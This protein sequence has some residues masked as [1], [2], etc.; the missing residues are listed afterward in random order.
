MPRAHLGANLTCKQTAR[1]LDISLASQYLTG[2]KTSPLI[3][4]GIHG[5]CRLLIGRTHS[6][7]GLYIQYVDASFITCQHPFARNLQADLRKDHSRL[8]AEL[9]AR[10][11]RHAAQLAE[12]A[13]ALQAEIDALKKQ[14]ESLVSEPESSTSD[15]RV[16]KDTSLLIFL[17]QTRCKL[18]YRSQFSLA[19]NRLC[20]A[21]E[22]QKRSACQ[23][24][25]NHRG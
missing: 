13:A 12:T 9:A 14:C 10:E 17:A 16:R 18:V 11:E 24:A 5:K 22:R 1:L 4:T 3:C 15:L 23:Q 25:A 2:A 8:E 6:H 20:H 19:R 21:A 7:H